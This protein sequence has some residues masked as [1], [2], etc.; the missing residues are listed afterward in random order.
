VGT[1]TAVAELDHDRLLAALGARLGVA[2]SLPLLRQALTHRSYSF[3]HGG[4]PTNER[5]EFLG[6]SVLGLVVTDALYRR[7]PERPEGQLAKIRSGVVSA[8]ALAEVA[9]DLDLGAAL[10]LGRGEEMTGGRA[11]ASILADALEA[12]IGAV[13]LEHGQHVATAVVTRLVGVRLDSAEAQRAGTDWKTDLQERA[14]AGGL[15]APVY[16]VAGSGP[17]HARRYDATVSVEGRV[18]GHGSGPSKKQAEQHAAEQACARWDELA[19]TR[20]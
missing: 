10:L 7:H 16:E 2:V 6:D 1:G 9:A 4:L 19:R 12:V 3:E 18:L 13:H 17:D 20:A 8:V 14:A 15:A 11:K 5:L